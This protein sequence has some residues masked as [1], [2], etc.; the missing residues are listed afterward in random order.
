MLSRKQLG[1]FGEDRATKYL[2]KNKYK[3]LARNWSNKWGEIDIVARKKGCFIFCEVKTIEKRSG[4]S[5][6]DEI[7]YKKTRQL[8]KMAQIYLSSNK[9]SFESPWQIDILAVEVDGQE[10]KI[11][12][13]KNAIEDQ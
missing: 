10:I 3:I 8:V 12:H 9:I 5:P 7:N 6:E 1:A 2:K 4:F 11:R 13:L